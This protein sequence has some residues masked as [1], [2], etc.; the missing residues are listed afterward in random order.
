MYYTTNCD[1]SDPFKYSKDEENCGENCHFS[2]SLSINESTIYSD[3]KHKTIHL[4]LFS[5]SQIYLLKQC[6]KTFA[7]QQNSNDCILGGPC[8][9]IMNI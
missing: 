2:T 5:Y 6:Y 9:G 8:S 3:F 4:Q 1:N 7:N